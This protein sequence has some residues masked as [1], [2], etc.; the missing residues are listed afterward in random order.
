M[1]KPNPHEFRDDV[2]RVAENREPGVPLR[3]IAA[4]AESVLVVFL[5]M[6]RWSKR[7]HTEHDL[8]NQGCSFSRCTQHGSGDASVVSRRHC[9][10]PACRTR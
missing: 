2:V 1:P 8:I 3:Q 9:Y 6:Q 4:C 5:V 10:Q 7:R